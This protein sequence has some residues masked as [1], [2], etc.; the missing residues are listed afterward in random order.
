MR[1][2]A[3]TGANR[4][5]AILRIAAA[6]LSLTVAL[7][8]FA[9][10]VR[11]AN[12]IPLADHWTWIK[13][14]LIPF[15]EGRIGLDQYFLG[16]YT[17]LAHSHFAAL[18]FL[19][20]AY[21]YFAL[22]FY[23]QLVWGVVFYVAGALLIARQFWQWRR[24]DPNF[25]LAVLIGAIGYFCIT[26]DFPWFLVVFEYF[27]FA[28]ALLLL[29]AFDRAAQQRI[30][31]TAFLTLFVFVL[32]FA[33]SIGLAASIT[34]LCAAGLLTLTGSIRWRQFVQLLITIAVVL[35]S[36]RLLLGPGIPG[37]ETARG[38][39]LAALVRSP[40]VVVRAVLSSMSQPLVDNVVLRH[41]F[42]RPHLLRYGLGATVALGLCGVLWLYWKQHA[43]R[44][45][46][47]PPLLI[48][49]SFLAALAI[50][51][52]RYFDFGEDVLLA[53]RFTRLFA[54]YVVG[55]AL[56]AALTEGRAARAITST[57]AVVCV[58][59]YVVSA[60]HQW[61][62]IGHVHAYFDRAEQLIRDHEP[63]DEDLGRH[64]VRC[65]RGFCDDAILFMRERRLHVFR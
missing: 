25:H 5:G 2:P 26:S 8:T 58:A 63:G 14:L 38:A 41:H 31:W 24:D 51:T 27:Y 15:V 3:T 34:V 32:T 16:Q 22:N 47:L 9:Y 46:I 17:F 57:F 61:R 1:G 23:L 50:L 40:E 29:V 18:A 54:L 42:D 10:L 62:H 11:V 35:A 52:S 20:I 56:A 12:N 7:S 21:Q 53:Q 60:S 28:L 33:D 13:G 37:S 65:S 43:Y 44:R 19:L 39:A 64:L 45:T 30:P 4:R 48:A 59:A 36:M 55:F 6:L 49:F